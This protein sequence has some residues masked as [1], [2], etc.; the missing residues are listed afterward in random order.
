MR[1][2][3]GSLPEPGAA[4]KLL[5][6]EVL[7]A[8]VAA[9]SE[10]PN[11][12]QLLE[13]AKAGQLGDAVRLRLSSLENLPGFVQVG[14]T[15][16]RI[17][18][19]AATGLSVTPIY[20]DVNVGTSVQATSRI[21]D[22]GQALVQLYVERSGIAKPTGPDAASVDPLEP[23]SIFRTITQTTVRAKLGE[24]LLISTGPSS[25]TTS[26]QTWIVLLVN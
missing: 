22:D 17:Q 13:L 21:G 16:A 8:D 1:G 15:V 7:I 24:P 3:L 11:A 6:L 5:T 9:S 2:G 20:S 25:T 10:K 18:G 4:G 19:R 14:E 23:K 26:V 12:A